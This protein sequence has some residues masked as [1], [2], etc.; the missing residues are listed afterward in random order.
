MDIQSNLYTKYSYPISKTMLSLGNNQHETDMLIAILSYFSIICWKKKYAIADRL[1]GHSYRTILNVIIHF[2][3]FTIHN[4]SKTNIS[5]ER[6][7]AALS[8]GYGSWEI[9][10]GFQHSTDLLPASRSLYT[11]LRFYYILIPSFNFS[12]G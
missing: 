3:F 12:Y 7:Y 10:F 2:S 1:I 4:S 8:K 5:F 11:V 9:I 6:A